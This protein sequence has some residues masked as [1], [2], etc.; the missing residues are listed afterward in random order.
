[1]S[2]KYKSINPKNNKLL[3]TYDLFTQ[4]QLNDRMEKAHQSFKIM[5][6]DGEAG[7]LERLNKL[8]KLKQLLSAKK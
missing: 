4:A 7:V 5:R 6:R 2:H 1:M 3:R 8:D